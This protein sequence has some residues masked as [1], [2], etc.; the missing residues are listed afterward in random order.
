MTTYQVKITHQA[1]EHLTFIRDYITIQLKSPESA[2]KLLHLFQ[3]R[4]NSL[5]F[6]PQR[7]SC[8]KESPWGENG[9]RK[10]RVEKYYIYFG[11][12][13][14]KKQVQIIAVI[15]SKRNQE[16]QLSFAE[17]AT[18]DYPFST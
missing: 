12:I 14:D 4:M 10:I 13:E 6:M 1:K 16:K 8:I 15:Y 17:I 3:T 9:I 18:E 2:K 11:I 7:I 5:S